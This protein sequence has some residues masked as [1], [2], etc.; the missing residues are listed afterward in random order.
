M[1]AV[2]LIANPLRVRKGR[3]PIRTAFY[4]VNEICGCLYL[5][6]CCKLVNPSTRPDLYVPERS[7]YRSKTTSHF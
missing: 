7:E 5:T 2:A 6:A 4:S 1:V 3:M